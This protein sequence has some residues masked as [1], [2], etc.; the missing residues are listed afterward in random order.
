VRRISITIRLLGLWTIIT[1]ITISIIIISI[2][3]IMLRNVHSENDCSHLFTR[4]CE[5]IGTANSVSFRFQEV[6]KL[7]KT[8]KSVNYGYSPCSPNSVIEKEKNALQTPFVPI[9]SRGT[10]FLNAGSLRNFQH[11]VLLILY[12]IYINL[13]YY[14]QTTTI[15]S[16]YWWSCNLL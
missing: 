12:F 4:W 8:L 10:T 2:I 11:E 1:I 3:S 13:K 15:K 9:F 5:K 16:L 14:I 7:K 6:Q